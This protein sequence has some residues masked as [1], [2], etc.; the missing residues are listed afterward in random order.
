MKS[1]HRVALERCRVKAVGDRESLHRHTR[2]VH[3]RG[4]HVVDVALLLDLAIR[5]FVCVCRRHL[6]RPS[7][8]NGG[9]PYAIESRVVIGLSQKVY[10]S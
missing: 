7:W 9:N 4:G 6:F 5:F 2:A 3:V 8:K 1:G 10:R